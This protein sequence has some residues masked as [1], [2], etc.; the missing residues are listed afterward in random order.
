MN[1]ELYK[2]GEF[3]RLLNLTPRTIRYYDQV[4]L[5]PQI[6]RSDGGIRLFDEKDI[7]IIKKVRIL[8]KEKLLPLEEIKEELFKSK[9]S[10]VKSTAIL[11]D[12]SC[13]LTNY[14][15]TVC[16][17]IGL[18][19]HLD[20]PLD[21]KVTP[22]IAQLWDASVKKQTIPYF[23]LPNK[24]EVLS[25]LEKLAKDGIKTVFAVAPSTLFQSLFPL[26]EELSYST[27]I[28]L[29]FYPI[30]SNAFGTST[31]LLINYIQKLIE[32]EKSVSE[33]KL[34]IDK[35]IPLLYQIGFTQSLDVFQ[36][37]NA[38]SQSFPILTDL[39]AFCP[40]YKMENGTGL[41]SIPQCL[42]SY[43]D[44]ISF[45]SEEVDKLIVKRK[46]YIYKII[47][48]YS[49]FYSE[50]MIL[51]NQLKQKYPNTDVE[52]Y[53]IPI[54]ISAIVGPKSMNITLL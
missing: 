49:Y 18:K 31:G 6:K 34:S 29:E 5:L 51:C 14:N 11:T 33:I 48:S 25:Q 52:I 21:K 40:I 53:E 2:I 12:S 24:S 43:Q 9:K 47:L 39:S 30:N 32:L 50:A 54:E 38:S 20:K 1:Q 16:K 46:K 23:Q 37:F 13:I 36:Q 17:V 41:W 22:G 4:G 44:A 15:A 10:C 42:P 28:P 7:Q 27:N 8:Q 26:Y 45:L 35:S 19:K 3:S